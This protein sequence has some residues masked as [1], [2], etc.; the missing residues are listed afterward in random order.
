MGPDFGRLKAAIR[1]G[2]MEE[3]VILKCIPQASK[4]YL[5][6]LVFN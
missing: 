5:I 2:V 4:T 1:I 3:F 6:A